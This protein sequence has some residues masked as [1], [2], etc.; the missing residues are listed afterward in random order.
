[1]FIYV[2]HIHIYV[3]IYICIYMYIYANQL[4]M[5]ANDDGSKTVNELGIHIHIYEE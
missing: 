2:I 5:I 1:M 4:R 3:Y